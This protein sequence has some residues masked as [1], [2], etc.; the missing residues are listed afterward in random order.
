MIPTCLLKNNQFD[1]TFPKEFSLSMVSYLDDPVSVS[2]VLYKAYKGLFKYQ[3]HSNFY[4]V[5]LNFRSKSLLDQPLE[6]AARG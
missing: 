3:I 5:S 1:V 4:V 6:L 2:E